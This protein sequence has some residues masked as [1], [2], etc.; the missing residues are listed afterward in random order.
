M[1]G[2]GYCLTILAKK[3]TIASSG[4]HFRSFVFREAGERGG[5]D[6]D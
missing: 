2:F 3:S 5:G 6:V 1:Q 4:E